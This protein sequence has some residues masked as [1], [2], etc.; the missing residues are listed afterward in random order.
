MAE[1]ATRDIVSNRRARYEY[2]LSD[3]FEAGIALL[4]SEVKGL[5]TGKGNLADAYVVIEDDGAW[6]QG[7][8]ISPYSHANRQ[9][10]E[11]LR[12][13]K[14]LLHK[15]EL[16]KLRKGTEEKGMTIVPTRVYLKGSLMKLEIALARGKKLHDKRDAIKDRDAERELR[17]IR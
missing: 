3:T 11:P 8:H 14:L 2:S 5:R 15:H 9:N 16:A 13:R 1:E 7:F 4:G 10:H 17:R 12:R 6:I